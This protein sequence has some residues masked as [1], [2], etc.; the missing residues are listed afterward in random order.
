MQWKFVNIKS[1]LSLSLSFS[2][3]GNEINFVDVL[4][5]R[6]RKSKKRH[7]KMKSKKNKKKNEIHLIFDNLLKDY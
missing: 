1:F 7:G 2:L 3:S 4:K 6:K 5:K